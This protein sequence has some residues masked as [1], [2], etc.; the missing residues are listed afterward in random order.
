MK[1]YLDNAATIPVDKEIFDLDL[2]VLYSNFHN[3][4]ANYSLSREAKKILEQARESLRSVFPEKN[5][6][7][8][9]GGTESDN[10]AIFSYS[11]R[12]NVVTTLGEHSAVYK[13]FEQLKQKG[14]EVR[15]ASV[16]YG[17]GVDEEDLLSKIDDN[18]TFVSVV[19][20]NNETGAIND[21]E[22]LAKKVKAINPKVIFHSDGVQGFC[23]V[24]AKIG[25][26][27]L[28]S[29]SAHKIGGMKGV[30]CL[31]YS[32]KLTIK[33]LLFGGG[34]E[35]GL[36]SGTENVFSI[37]VF[38]DCAKKRFLN[39]NINYEHAATLKNTAVGGLDKDLFKII[40]CEPCTPYILTFSAIGLKGQVLQSMLDDEGVLVGTGSACSSKA[41]FSRQISAFERSKTILDGVIRLGFSPETTIDELTAAINKINETAK[42]LH[43]KIN[44]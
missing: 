44:K 31:Y 14:L 8:T 28:Y 24:P 10:T 25:N 13:C 32:P 37:K 42:L 22:S 40:S 7:I 5:V 30:G 36:R 41:P 3:P 20:V 35:N 4:S 17:G 23:K 9:S 29:V 33:P 12:G 39:L 11:R 27:D 15:Y 18:T 43:G 38:A 16:K 21:I 2:P 34:Q 6:L 1:I 26:V 19:H